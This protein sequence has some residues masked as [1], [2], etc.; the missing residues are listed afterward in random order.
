MQLLKC[1]SGIRKSKPLLPKI[2]LARF[3]TAGQ[4]VG[5]DPLEFTKQFIPAERQAATPVLAAWAA[6]PHAG[7]D[8]ARAHRIR[9]DFSLIHCKAG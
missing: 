8:P 4:S 1:T 9:P 7:M 2:I 3:V 5:V 6:P